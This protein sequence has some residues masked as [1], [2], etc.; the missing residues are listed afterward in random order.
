MNSEDPGEGKSALKPKEAEK[1]LLAWEAPER[2]FKRR[3]RDFY[4][5]LLAMAFIFG[6]ILFLIDGWAPVILIVALVFLSYVMSTIEPNNVNY[7]ITTKGIYVSNESIPWKVLGRFW[8]S[9]RFDNDLLIVETL[10]F[11]GR[12][13]LVV[14]S[15]LK[16][17]IASILSKYL[18]LEEVPPSAL[19]KAANW[20]AKRAPA[21]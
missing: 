13:E 21:K 12:M 10:S 17:K 16:E 7:K 14:T 6:M 3:T 1:E 20:F 9:R 18:T 5:T 11:P 4:V 15:D 8:F 19:D 2:P